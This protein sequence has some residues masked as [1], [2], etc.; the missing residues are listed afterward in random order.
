[1]IIDKLEREDEID[2]VPQGLE[3]GGTPIAGCYYYQTLITP[4]ANV[5]HKTARL[6]TFYT[7]L[8]ANLVSK[9]D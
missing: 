8:Q 2:T 5:L 1:M 6:A 3:M 7:Q 9:A 4:E